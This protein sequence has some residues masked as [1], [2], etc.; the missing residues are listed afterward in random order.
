MVYYKIILLCL[1]D[2]QRYILQWKPYKILWASDSI[3]TK[4]DIHNVKLLDCE[5]ALSQHVELDNNLIAASD[6][7]ILSSCIAVNIGNFTF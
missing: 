2:L 5:Q 6:V 1:Q 3:S 7:Y 4:R